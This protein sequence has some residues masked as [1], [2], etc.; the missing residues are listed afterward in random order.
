MKYGLSKEHL[1][2]LTF[3]REAIRPFRARKVFTY[4]DG[5]VLTIER[6][7]E[8][9]E[10]EDPVSM[11]VGRVIGGGNGRVKSGEVEGDSGVED[12]ASTSA[13]SSGS[14]S[15]SPSSSSSSSSGRD[16]Q[17]FPWPHL[18]SKSMKPPG[19]FAQRLVAKC[20]GSSRPPRPSERRH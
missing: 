12:L 1:A 11:H 20:I 3:E 13:S 2:E 15:T 8:E 19:I 4:G 17:W 6:V 9:W 14:G 7:F 5:K 10:L 18:R 16:S